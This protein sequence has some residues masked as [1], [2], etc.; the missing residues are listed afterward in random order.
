VVSNNSKISLNCENTNT[1]KNSD[2]K[3]NINEN[4]VLH[5]HA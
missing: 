1:C 5:G 4:G 2:Y 3:V